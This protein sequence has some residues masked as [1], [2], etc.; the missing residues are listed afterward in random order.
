[1]IDGSETL[2]SLLEDLESPDPRRRNSAALR[3]RD[4]AESAVDA[5]FRAAARPE[6]CNHRGTLVHVLS[7]FNCEDHFP[8]LFDLA[9]HGNYEVQCHALSILQSQSF[10]VTAQQLR[11]ARQALGELR[12]REG[13]RAEDFGLLREEL[14]SALSR[15]STQ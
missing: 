1:M 14:Q 11:E 7:A 8:E 12:E 15:L 10:S 2:G 6:N 9:L 5:L 3:L 4:L 13:L